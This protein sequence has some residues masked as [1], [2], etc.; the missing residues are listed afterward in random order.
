MAQNKTKTV[1][2]IG[3]GI[4]GVCAAAHLLRHGLEVVVFERSGIA[5][6]VWHFDERSASDPSFPNELPSKGDYETRPELAFSTPPPEDADNDKLEIAHA[7]PGPCYAGLKN[8]VS[9][10]EMR[11][12][13]LSWP[14]GTEDFVNQKVLEEYIQNIA[15]KHGVSAITQYHTRVEDV[16]KHSGEWLVRTTTLQKG[17]SGSRFVER[18]WTFDAVVVASGHYN[19]PRVPD[20]PGLKEWKHGWPDRVWHS[21]R[22]RN[23]RIFKDQNII[24]IGAGVSANDIAKESA[25]YANHIYQ[26]SRDGTY[27]LPASFLPEG[28]TR[29]GAIKSF[30]LN[31]DHGVSTP[32]SGPIPGKVVLESGEVLTDIHSVILCTGYITSY[33]FL[34]HLH[35]DDIPASEADEFVLVTAE[36]DMAH[37]LHKDMF[38]I[39]DPSLV[40]IGA[41]YH[42]ATFSL[43]EFQGQAVARV[44]SGKA[45]LPSKQQMR[46]EYNERVRT[47]GLGRDF[48]S[49]KALGAEEEYVKDLVQ[50]VNKDAARLGIDDKMQGHT[51]EWH[52]AKLGREARMKLLMSAKEQEKQAKQE[53]IG[54]EKL[55]TTA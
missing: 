49:L 28:A 1:A 26:S 25:G 47:S 36:G 9:T 4:S 39:E 44:L 51:P 55:P 35:R 24:L 10:R 18:R 13:L 54:V 37:N 48:H 33:P 11:T 50:W 20:F 42:I 38:Y 21:K 46:D 43:F 19:M 16:R 41:P 27:D 31:E 53:R 5:G 14:E 17:P 12:S 6:G 15:I 2:V 45:E 30:K 23:P 40:F 8:N 29:I 22:Y 32:D 52:L 34:R 3:A 7:P